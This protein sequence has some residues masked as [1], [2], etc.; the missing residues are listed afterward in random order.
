MVLTTLSVARSTATSF[1]PPSG[2]GVLSERRRGVEDPEPVHRADDPTLCTLPSRLA[3][4][5]WIELI[6]RRVGIWNDL[7]VADFRDCKGISTA[8]S[9]E[10]DEDPT[11]V[12]ATVYPVVH[13]VTKFENRLDVADR[14]ICRHAS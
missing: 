13:V 9:W 2:T 10:A 5:L 6:Y 14:T 3:R 12:G 7:S 11:V 4:T 8:P 1:A